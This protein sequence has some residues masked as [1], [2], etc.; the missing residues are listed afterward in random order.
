[1]GP[2]FAVHERREW[3]DAPVN[4]GLFVRWARMAKP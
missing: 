3:A 1:M 4:D 2:L